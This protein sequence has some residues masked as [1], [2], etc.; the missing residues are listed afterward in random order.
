MVLPIT[1]DVD[2]A[3]PKPFVAKP[4]LLDNPEARCVF[5]PDAD[6][7][8]VKAQCEKAMIGGQSN[9]CRSEPFACESFAHPVTDG[10]R[11]RRAAAD[12]VQRDRAQQLAIAADQEQRQR[13]AVA[14]G[15]LRPIDPVG[16]AFP[17]MVPSQI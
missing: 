17:F 16:K 1:I 5:G 3:T 10:R 7:H 14:A 11:L 9:G 15:A 12:I 13:G 2:V 6:L 8:A 4:Q